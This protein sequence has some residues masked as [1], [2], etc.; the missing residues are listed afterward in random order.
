MA[1][2]PSTKLAERLAS[3]LRDAGASVELVWQPTSHGL[4]AGDVK[5]GQRF[6]EQA[7]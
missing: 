4:T 3:I 1:G 7:E 6:F 5:V 2:K